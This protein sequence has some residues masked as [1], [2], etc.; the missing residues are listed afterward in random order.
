M[1]L[2]AW[3]CWPNKSLASSLRQQKHRSFD[4]ML[5]VAISVFATTARSSMM[6]QQQ[7]LQNSN[8]SFMF[9]R[10]VK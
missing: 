7:L 1:C 8:I 9:A 3:H 6:T 5:L 2:F 4:G 10:M